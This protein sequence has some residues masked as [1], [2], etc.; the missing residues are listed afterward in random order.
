MIELKKLNGTSIFVN[1]DMIRA[2][3]ATPDTVVNFLDGETI[4]VLNTPEEIVS[5]IVSFRKS[6]LNSQTNVD[7]LSS[8]LLGKQQ[9]LQK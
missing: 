5:S 7:A 4:L 1:P 8:Q 6:Y 9:D 3:E 2:V